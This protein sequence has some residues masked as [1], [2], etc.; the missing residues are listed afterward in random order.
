MTNSCSTPFA[1]PYGIAKRQNELSWH[2]LRPTACAP[3]EPC[4][5]TQQTN[6]CSTSNREQHP[7][8]SARRRNGEKGSQI[9]CR[10][11]KNDPKDSPALVLPKLTCI[12]FLGSSEYERS[13]DFLAPQS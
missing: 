2:K 11:D 3:S 6:C 7:K 10:I 1:Q 9:G 13:I 5:N 12:V 8:A 4:G